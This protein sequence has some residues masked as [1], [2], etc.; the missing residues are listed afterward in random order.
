VLA[1]AA[2]PSDTFFSLILSLSYVVACR[3]LVDIHGWCPKK[4]ISLDLCFG[5]SRNR[6]DSV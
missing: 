6:R 5:G 2:T 3:E 4:A 1:R